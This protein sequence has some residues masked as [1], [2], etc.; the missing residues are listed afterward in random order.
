[1][2]SSVAPSEFGGDAAP[3]AERGALG[4]INDNLGSDMTRLGKNCIWCEEPTNDSDVSH[5]LPECFG[6][7]DAQVLPKG[8]VCRS[9][10]N[11][12]HFD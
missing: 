9:C 5:V 6:N 1:V 7:R 4:Q 12:V 2:H 10:N 11:R 8:T 3:A